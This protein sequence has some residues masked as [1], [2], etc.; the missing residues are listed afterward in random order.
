MAAVISISLLTMG[1]S[2]SMRCYHEDTL[3]D[4]FTDACS[5]IVL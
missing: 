5:C 4:M 3:I 1:P 2:K